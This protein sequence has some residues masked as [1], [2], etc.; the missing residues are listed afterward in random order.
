MDYGDN[1]RFA[2]ADLSGKAAVGKSR[3]VITFTFRV[4]R[5]KSYSD[6]AVRLA[7][8]FATDGSKL[9]TSPQYTWQAVKQTKKVNKTTGT[10]II[11]TYDTI[12]TQ[13]KVAARNLLSILKLDEAELTPKFDPKVKQYT[14]TVP[15]EIEKVTVTAV[16]ADPEATVTIGDTNLEYVGKNLVSIKVVSKTGLKRTYKIL[17]T[18]LDP[19]G[20]ETLPNESVE[21]ENPQGMPAWLITLICVSA[22]I[23]AA[24]IV[25]VIIILIK[26]RK[27]A[28]GDL[29]VI[30]E[31]QPTVS[32][33]D[34]N[35]Q[36]DSSEN[37][38]CSD[39]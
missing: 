33:G 14:A 32:D 26:K 39:K 9:I 34:D 1:I 20:S 24:C 15:Y 6:A 29:K 7:E 10:K 3:A 16:A 25:L 30:A 13:Q 37:D 2:A 18:R 31:E 21:I 12:V 8:L 36:R 27:S 35:T 5:I 11:N 23:I 19:E 17:V 28:R 22:A 4:G 38:G